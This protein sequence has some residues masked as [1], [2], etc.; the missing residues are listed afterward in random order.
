MKNKLWIL[1]CS[2]LLLSSTAA[3]SS[4][5]S[6]FAASSLQESLREVVRLYQ[7][8]YPTIQVQLN[9]AGSQALATQIEQGAPADL[10]ISANQQL[11]ERLQRQTLLTDVQPML[12]NRLLIVARSDLKGQI[13]EVADLAR[14]GLLLAIGN[15]QVP[16]GYYTRKF[17]DRLAADPDIGK[18]LRQRIEANIVSEENRFKAIIAKLQLGEVDAGIVYRTDL[19]SKKGRQLQA[20]ELPERYAPVAIYPLAKVANAAKEADSFYAFLLSGT[21]RQTAV[22]ASVLLPVAALLFNTDWSALPKILSDKEILSALW[23]TLLSSVIAF[24]FVLLLGLPSAYGLSRCTGRL[25]RALDILL[26]LPMVMPPVVAGLA[27]LLAFGRRGLTGDLLSA[28]N[29]R[30]PFTLTAVVVGTLFVV[31]PF[32]VRRCTLL[33]ESIDPKLEEAALLLGASP[34]QAF[35][36]VALPVVKRGLFAET[37]M[38]LA[39]GVGLFG[40]IILFAGN[41]P[42]RTQTLSLA[43]YSAFESDPRQAFTLGTLLLSISLVLLAIARILGPREST[44]E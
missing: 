43:I 20:T 4:E 33:F 7:A 24:P 10:F 15:P 17:F 32:F 5:L 9:F 44:D 21:A 29:L 18:D 26:E 13:K 38:A 28:F 11:V 36:H 16:I 1:L 23:I 6:V 25:R 19:N 34:R 27:L 12:T 30:I 31:T 39:Q 14:P 41:L 22:A 8:E 40:V 35:W 42:G 3:Q 2:L 37:V